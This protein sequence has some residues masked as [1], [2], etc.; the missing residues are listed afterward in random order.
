LVRLSQIVVAQRFGRRSQRLATAPEIA[1]D[2]L[3][4]VGLL[5]ADPVDGDP[6]HPHVFLR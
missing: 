2:A 5:L 4:A 6:R 1:A 3:L